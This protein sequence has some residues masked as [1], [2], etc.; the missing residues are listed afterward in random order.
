MTRHLLIAGAAVAA[1]TLAACNQKPAETAAEAT[2]PDAN[3]A[4]TV[5]TPA[6]EA[7]APDFVTKAASSDIYEIAAAKLALDHA[8]DPKVRAFAQSMIDAHT[9]SSEALKKA[10]ADSA[11]PLTMPT[12]LPADLQSRL[13]DLGKTDPAG[14]DKAYVD[15]QVAAHQDALNLMRR[16]AEDGDSQPLKDFASATG[17][18]VQTHYDQA[19][20]LQDAMS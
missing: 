9:K 15:D 7:A 4:A 1:L 10:V 14:F 19:K 16:Y 17:A 6:D 13:D 12:A 20:A 18:V 3:A 11:E 2:M 5:P 8:K